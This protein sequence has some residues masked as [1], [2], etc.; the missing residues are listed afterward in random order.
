MDKVD[1]TPKE[2]K[3]LYGLI[4]YPKATDKELSDLLA[5]KHSTITAI[6]NR[7][8]EQGYF[9]PLNIPR[10]QNFGC[11]NLVVIYTNFSPLIPLEERV[12]ITGK[13][14]E[15]FEEIFY[16][17]G[18]QEKGFSLSLSK[19]YANI[20]RINDIRTETFGSRGLL[21]DEYPNMIIFPFEISRIYR[22]F[23]FAPLLSKQFHL[24][25]Y[26][27][28]K[29]IDFGQPT[30]IQPK[31]LSD[32]QKQVYCML[33]KYPEYTD[34]EIGEKLTI[35][36]H[37]V[38]RVRRDFEDDEFIRRI[39]LPNLKKMGFEILTLIHIKFD[40]RKHPDIEK[41]EATALMT[42]STV[43]MACRM[44]EAFMLLVHTDYDNFSHD[45]MRIMQLLK[46]KEWISK[47]PMIRTHSL[48]DL[49]FIKDFVFTPIAKKT[50]GCDLPV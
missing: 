17:I 39:H 32:I 27:P 43:L 15:V 13:T 40:P 22:F 5:I 24:D 1:L 47:S 49:V 9:R 45:S 23:D 41:D 44:F 3:T 48:R 2:K 35:S 11:G 14:I 21:E 12:K 26:K 8:Q 36:R 19:D 33:I 10:L 37:T 30:T 7:L 42:D 31:R 20:G 28:Q 38:S 50:I 6:R 18:E 16:S 29:I 34:K 4:H 25:M 46:E